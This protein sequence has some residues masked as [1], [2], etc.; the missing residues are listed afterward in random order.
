MSFPIISENKT[1]LLQEYATKT[2]LDHLE[3]CCVTEFKAIAARLN[4]Q[5]YQALAAEV[6][7]LKEDLQAL[8]TALQGK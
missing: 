6:A 7:K 4:H 2:D 8:H 5:N 3:E 1:N